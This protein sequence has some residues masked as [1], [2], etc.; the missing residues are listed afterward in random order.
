M[1]VIYFQSKGY[2]SSFLISLLGGK[3]IAETMAI[4]E[5][6][7]VAQAQRARNTSTPAEAASSPAS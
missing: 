1:S 6:S 7:A 2:P 4:L 3:N 5:L